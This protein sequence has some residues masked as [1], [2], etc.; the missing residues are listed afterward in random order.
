MQDMQVAAVGLD[1]RG[2]PLLLVQERAGARR[3][4]PVSIGWPEAVNIEI[5]LAGRQMPR[6]L[7]H[8]LIVHVVEGFGRTLDR[9]EMTELKDGIFYADLVLDQGV[10]ISARV[11]DA[12]AIALHRNVP[13]R[14]ATAVLEAAG[15]RPDDASDQEEDPA[16]PSVPDIDAE[17]SRFQEQ[18]DRIDPEDFGTS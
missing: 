8:Q 10:R 15:V 13:I 3:V 16:A 12:I 2:I 4:L 18:L 11:S 14:A 1:A 5:E 17:V 7:T 6:P 9:V